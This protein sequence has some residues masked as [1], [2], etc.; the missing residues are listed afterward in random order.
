MKK[1]VVTKQNKTDL[2]FSFRRQVRIT[3][4][5]IYQDKFFTDKIYRKFS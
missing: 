1:F 2:Q 5:K 3:K 4:I